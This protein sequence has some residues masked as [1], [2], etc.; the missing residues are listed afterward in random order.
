MILLSK[1]MVSQDAIEYN[2]MSKEYQDY[3]SWKLMLNS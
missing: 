3:I 2:K 1:R